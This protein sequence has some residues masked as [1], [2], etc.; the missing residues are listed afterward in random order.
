[1]DPSRLNKPTALNN[2]GSPAALTRYKSRHDH[3]LSILAQWITSVVKDES[4]GFRGFTMSRHTSR[5]SELFVSLRPDIAIKC[6][7]RISTLELTICHE[8]NINAS[9]Q[10]KRLKIHQFKSELQVPQ[11]SRSNLSTNTVEVSSLGFISDISEFSK[12]NLTE[13]MPDH[14]WNNWLSPLSFQ[15]H[16]SI[17]CLR[18]VAWAQIYSQIHSDQVLDPLVEYEPDTVANIN[19]LYLF[20][21]IFIL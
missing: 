1:M 20:I 7:N 4:A 2:C 11:F 19:S 14:V 5:L 9:K 13:K 8:T 6:Q 18:N 3:V 21:F 12:A 10:F 16:R 15:I 17:Y